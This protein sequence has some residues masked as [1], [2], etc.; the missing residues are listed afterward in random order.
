MAQSGSA[1]GSLPASS[2]PDKTQKQ[3]TTSVPS[4]P[5]TNG[6][7]G[8]ERPGLGIKDFKDEYRVVAEVLAYFEIASRRTFDIVP[9][10]TEYAFLTG[11]SNAL[12]DGLAQ[13]LGLMG[14]NGLEKCRNY[15]VENPEITVARD[16]LEGRIKILREASD[17]INQI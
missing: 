2:S 13:E 3:S 7:N 9:M 10:I 12:R 1:Y 8:S 11:F 17:I 5:Q 14:E 16:E 6:L 4:I 15:A